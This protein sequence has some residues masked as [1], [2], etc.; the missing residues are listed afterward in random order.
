MENF[1]N[2]VPVSKWNTKFEFP[3][4]AS[5]R[6]LIFYNRNNFENQVIKT[7]GKRQYVDTV[8]FQEWIEENIV[9]TMEDDFRVA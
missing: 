1:L 6:Q 4:V 2:L 7:I 9:F 5:I 3:S 8:K